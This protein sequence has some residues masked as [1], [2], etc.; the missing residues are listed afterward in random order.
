MR[1][2]WLVAI[3]AV[4]IL[5]LAVQNVFAAGST[6]PD[7][8]QMQG[9]AQVDQS[10]RIPRLLLSADSANGGDYHVDATL[11]PSAI[12][13]QGGGGDREGE[14]EGRRP[15]V[16]Q[17]QSRGQQPQR[18]GTGLVGTFTLSQNGQVVSSGQATGLLNRDGTGSLTLSDDS[19]GAM[20][21]D[22]SVD[23]SGLLDATLSGPLPGFA[24]SPFAGQSPAIVQGSATQP[25]NGDH[26]FWYLARAA[27][28]SAYLVLFLNVVFGLAVHT[29]VMDGIY[30]RWRSL[31][32]HQFTTL[33]ALGLLAI[34]AFALLGDHYINF[35]LPEILVPLLSPYR[36]AWTATGIIGA[37]LMIVVT[38]TSY[39][40]KRMSYGTW[41]SLHY[42]SFGAYVLALGHG[43]FSGTDTSQPWAQALYWSTGAVVIG[44]TVWRFRGARAHEAPRVPVKQ[45]TPVRRGAS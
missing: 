35:T 32:L 11:S 21:F 33:L 44:L 45:G 24:S 10:Q 27:G 18:G 39:L 42:L 1:A 19:G 17:G 23:N 8:Q 16:G 38:V 3:V 2:R 28:L 13:I 29:K 41:R 36:P 37:Y 25:D 6:P 43:I 7:S 9:S 40:R 31:D 20:Q 34:H 5:V 14:R 12:G 22:F 4:A 30:A 15:S 26:T